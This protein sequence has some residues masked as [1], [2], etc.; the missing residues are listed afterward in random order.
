MKNP[1]IKTAN[2]GRR[3]FLGLLLAPFIARFHR[4]KPKLLWNSEVL[5]RAIA[6]WGK[7]FDKAEWADAASMSTTISIRE[8]VPVGFQD[9]LTLWQLEN[10]I[11]ADRRYQ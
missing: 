4:P 8:F 6:T 9:P 2:L 10:G 3:G 11:P 7:P 1:T 5:K